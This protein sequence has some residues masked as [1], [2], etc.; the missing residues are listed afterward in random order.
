[1]QHKYTYA[2]IQYKDNAPYLAVLIYLMFIIKVLQ[3]C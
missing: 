3:M 1:M 2:I